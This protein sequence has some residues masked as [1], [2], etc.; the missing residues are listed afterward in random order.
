[1][2]S[3]SQTQCIHQ[4]QACQLLCKMIARRAIGA[5]C[6]PGRQPCRPQQ[7]PQLGAHLR[8]QQLKLNDLSPARLFNMIASPLEG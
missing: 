5:L 8:T 7:L 1:V 6:I 2:L 4:L 3:S